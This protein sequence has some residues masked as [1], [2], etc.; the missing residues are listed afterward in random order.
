MWR[1]S[2]VR[3]RGRQ[4]VK[5]GGRSRLGSRNS[6]PEALGWANLWRIQGIGPESL[7]GQQGRAG[8]RVGLDFILKATGSRGRLLV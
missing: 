3:G 6:E 4:R 1:L 2:C 5:N 8:T 7:R